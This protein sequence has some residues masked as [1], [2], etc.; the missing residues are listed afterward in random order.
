VISPTL[1]LISREIKVNGK[2]EIEGVME[3]IPRTKKEN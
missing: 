3:F 1:R 2:R